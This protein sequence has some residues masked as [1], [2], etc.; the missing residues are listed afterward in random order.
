MSQRL[1]A[2]AL[3]TDEFG[4]AM[5]LFQSGQSVPFLAGAEGES[6]TDDDKP[7]DDTSG[8]TS[9]DDDETDDD[10]DDDED[11]D[12]DEK[13]DPKKLSERMRAAD[14]RASK[15]ERERDALLAEKKKEQDAKKGDLERAQDRVKELEAEI[16]AKETAVKELQVQVAFFSV[17]GK[18][19]PVWIDPA[20]ALSKLDLSEVE[21]DEK[22]GAID[23][24]SLRKAIKALAAEKPHWVKK[25]DDG[26][27]SSTEASGSQMNG[28]RKGG[29][30]AP[31]AAALA[32]DFPALR[33]RQ[34]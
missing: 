30:D 11:K 9:D 7:D 19:M 32:K 18:D 31:D 13:P 5:W 24:K 12:D 23:K 8:V 17:G 6:S 20:D 10:G 16:T 27:D 21:M 26:S 34:V 29:K 3:V 25:D 1:T 28:K 15:L 14:R 2:P 22:T 4:K 33:T